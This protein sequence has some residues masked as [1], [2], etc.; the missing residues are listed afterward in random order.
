MKLNITVTEDNII[1][2]QRHSKCA[3]PIALAT[4][5]EAKRIAD[6]EDASRAHMVY[7]SIDQTEG[8][9]NIDGN[10][11]S[12]VLPKTAQDFIAARDRKESVSPFSFSATAARYTPPSQ[13]DTMRLAR[14][15]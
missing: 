13:L 14:A 2:S 8:R 9:V 3:C 7:A 5:A 10:A 12:F 4:A 6:E 1:K 11:W 15:V